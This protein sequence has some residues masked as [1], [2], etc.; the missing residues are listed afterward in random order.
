MQAVVE[1]P[2]TIAVTLAFNTHAILTLSTCK[3][4]KPFATIAASYLLERSF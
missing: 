1:A 4:G 3:I 2:I